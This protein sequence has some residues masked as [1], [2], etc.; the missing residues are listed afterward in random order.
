MFSIRLA[1]VASCTV[2][3]LLLTPAFAKKPK[4][5][6]PPAA[7]SPPAQQN[8]TLTTT[9]QS[10]QKDIDADRVAL[11]KANKDLNDAVEQADSVVAAKKAVGDATA[12][13]QAAADAVKAKLA[14]NADYKAAVAKE[15]ALRAQLDDLRNSNAT[16]DQ[17]SDKATEVFNAGSVT[18]KLERDANAVD[19]KYVDAQ[20]TLADA[21]AALTAARTAAK[22]DPAVAT[23]KTTRDD[24]QKKLA[25]AQAKLDAD[26][27]S[28]T[29]NAG[30]N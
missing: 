7:A 9:L 14:T 13:E 15:T 8:N 4:N 27:K 3:T 6:A 26:R 10:D 19:P 1:L 5:S 28:A 23:L 17:I 22:N 30:S 21:N 29:A 24:A 12:A 16:Q 2:T 20:K 11:T 18:S 25:D